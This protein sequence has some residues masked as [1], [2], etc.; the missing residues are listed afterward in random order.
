MSNLFPTWSFE[1]GSIGLGGMTSRTAISPKNNGGIA[2]LH[3]PTIKALWWYA[4]AALKPDE[5]EIAVGEG[6]NKYTGEITACRNHM[7]DLQ[8]KLDSLFSKINLKSS[9]LIWWTE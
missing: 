4:K 5:A 7:I 1:K 2:T 8:K 9:N 6:E 3:E